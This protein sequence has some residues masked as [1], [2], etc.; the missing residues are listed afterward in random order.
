MNENDNEVKNCITFQ[1]KEKVYDTDEELPSVMSVDELQKYTDNIT[2]NVTK[3]HES[4][5]SDHIILRVVFR[6]TREYS[7]SG[8]VN[9]NIR[10]RVG[11]ENERKLSFFS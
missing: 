6:L 1:I 7:T 10:L 9:Y 8:R 5:V 2:Q 11:P 4:I 3:M